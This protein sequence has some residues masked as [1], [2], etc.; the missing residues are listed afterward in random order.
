DLAT[1]VEW[2]LVGVA[3]G[4]DPF[5]PCP[6]PQRGEVEVAR[7]LAGEDRGILVFRDDPEQDPRGEQSEQRV[8][9][10]QEQQEPPGRAGHRSPIRWAIWSRERPMNH[11][12][13]GS[14]S[15]ATRR[16]SQPGRSTIS[17]RQTTRVESPSGVR[18]TSAPPSS[19]GPT[20][21]MVKCLPGSQTV[22]TMRSTTDSGP[23]PV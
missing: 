3:L 2:Q 1:V 18:C 6:V 22:T 11:R 14:L 23:T 12:I 4:R 15:R 9:A 7:H 5:V 19:T 10:Q 20:L 8:E 16:P 13:A 21:T 17:S